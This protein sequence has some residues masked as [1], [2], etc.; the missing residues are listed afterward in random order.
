MAQTKPE[1]KG[2]KGDTV[3]AHLS[4][5]EIVIPRDLAENEEFR[6]VLATVFKKGGTDLEK[7]IV[8]RPENARNPDTGYLEFWSLKSTFKKVTRSISRA[9]SAV[10]DV[11]SGVAKGVGGLLGMGRIEAPEMPSVQAEQPKRTAAAMKQPPTDKG[12]LRSLRM[13]ASILTEDWEKP[14]LGR[15]ALLGW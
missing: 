1:Q 7:F 5:G 4:I 9:F 3:L 8:G 13:G 2:R 6:S 15:K 14:K 10:G 11:I 12:T